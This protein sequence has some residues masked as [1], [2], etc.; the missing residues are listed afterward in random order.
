MI[1]LISEL[2]ACFGL[3]ST[4]EDAEENDDEEEENANS[5]ELYNEWDTADQPYSK[6]DIVRYYG[7]L[8]I[9]LKDQPG[10]DW[11]NWDEM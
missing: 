4:T 11:D 1:V 7:E 10:E 9:A 5:D 8:F 2:Q 6:D 3:E